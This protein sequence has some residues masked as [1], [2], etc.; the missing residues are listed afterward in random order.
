MRLG[1]PADPLAEKVVL[2]LHHWHHRGQR[3]TVNSGGGIANPP[4]PSP[5]SLTRTAYACPCL[6]VLAI[7]RHLNG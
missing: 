3:H 5:V 2:L 4:N 7:W 6:E 1:L